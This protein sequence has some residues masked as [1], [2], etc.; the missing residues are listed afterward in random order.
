V[1]LRPNARAWQ[2]LGAGKG[3]IRWVDSRTTALNEHPLAPDW[4]RQIRSRGLPWPTDLPLEPLGPSFGGRGDDAAAWYLVQSA[5]PS[6]ELW[7]LDK[8]AAELLS[9]AGVA[10]PFRGAA[11]AALVDEKRRTQFL[12]LGVP[13]DRVGKG[14][15]LRFR[16]V[17][18]QG[19]PAGREVTD[20]VTVP[21]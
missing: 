3:R 6:L 16:L 10:E 12:Y 20:L 13:A 11:G 14:W 1:A 21:W 8:S 2:S 4:I 9:P 19:G 5:R 17:R 18:Y 15:R 7:N